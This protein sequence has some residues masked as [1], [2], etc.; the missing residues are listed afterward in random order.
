[1]LMQEEKKKLLD[2]WINRLGLGDWTI[3]ARLNASPNEFASCGAD[4]ECCYTESTKVANIRIM[5]EDALNDDADWEQIL[6]HELLH[7]KFSLI[8]PSNDDSVKG[9]VMHQLID[10]M[11]KAL[12]SAKRGTTLAGVIKDGAEVEGEAGYTG[13]E[14]EEAKEDKS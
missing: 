8:Y 3:R 1:M 14:D 10:D 11:S 5:C 13:N 7:C 9:R 2:E 4:G 12:V 6:V